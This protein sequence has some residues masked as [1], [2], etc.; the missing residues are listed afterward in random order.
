VEAW[1][2]AR[3]TDEVRVRVPLA[4]R[5]ERVAGDGWLLVGDATGFLDPISGE[6]IHR[7]FASAELA[8]DAI[9]EWA[10]G[11]RPGLAGYDA[12]LRARFRP[13]D[14]LSW[15]LQAFITRPALFDYALGRL[16]RRPELRRTFG[17]VMADLEPADRALD[18]AFVVRLLAP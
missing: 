4:H 3:E 17:S 10:T 16:S 2:A 13:K 18:P 9:G 1:R 8:A 6:G 15:L 14:T 5:V 11:D 12:A 7:A